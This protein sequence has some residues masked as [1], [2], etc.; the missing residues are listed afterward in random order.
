[1][2]A[3]RSPSPPPQPRQD[4]TEQKSVR[5]HAGALVA[6]SAV[7]IPP[8]TTTLPSVF[9]T[10]PTAAERAHGR[11]DDARTSPLQKVVRIHAGAQISVTVVRIRAQDDDAAVRLPDHPGH[12]RAYPWPPQSPRTNGF[13]FGNRQHDSQI[14]NF[15]A[16]AG[17]DPRRRYIAKF[18]HKSAYELFKPN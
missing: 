15:A 17:P 11:Q 14:V 13:H 18:V 9:Q 3:L 1:M 8:R 5:I 4:V 2:P 6:V 10:I 7:R 12:G 16:E